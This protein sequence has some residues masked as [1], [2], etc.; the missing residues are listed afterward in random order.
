MKNSV[1]DSQELNASHEKIRIQNDSSIKQQN[2]ESLNK[3]I[4]SLFQ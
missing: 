3:S 4:D 1:Q 2:F